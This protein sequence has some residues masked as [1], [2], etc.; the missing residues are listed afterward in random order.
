MVFIPFA[1]HAAV[2]SLAV[3]AA[4]E[5]IRY[6]RL[7]NTI[8]LSIAMLFPAYAII[9]LTLSETLAHVVAGAIM[10]AIGFGLYLARVWGGGDAKLLAAIA[11][12]PAV[13]DVPA[14][15]MLVTIAGGALALIAL[16][17]KHGKI[18]PKMAVRAP[19][20]YGPETGWFA[21]L[22]RGE[23]VVPYGVAIALGTLIT[24]F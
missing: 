22:T 21:S 3:W 18:L 5:D 24:L 4:F 7:R 20:I 15:L 8:A 17:L 14:L 19:W 9:T 16:A 11:L 2:A 12:W 10:F 23:T 6:M 13:R 1:F